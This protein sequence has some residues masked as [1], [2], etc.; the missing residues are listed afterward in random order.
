MLSDSRQPLAVLAKNRRSHGLVVVLCWLCLAAGAP[1]VSIITDP[2]PA[3]PAV[4]GMNKLV[5]ALRSRQINVEMA[6]TP[7][8]ARGQMILFA[9]LATA[10]SGPEALSITRSKITNKP[11]V[12]MS[13]SDDIGL[14]YAE[15]DVADRVGWA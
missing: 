2:K 11:A 15:L 9:Q 3:A 12:V 7:A 6:E 14:M 13:G 5:E 10:P 4:H 8:A 1:V